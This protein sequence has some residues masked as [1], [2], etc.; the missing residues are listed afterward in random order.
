MKDTTFGGTCQID[1]LIEER[2]GLNSVL[3]PSQ[4]ARVQRRRKVSFK[5]NKMQFAKG[6]GSMFYIIT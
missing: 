4:E 2:Y 3:T 6:Y 1:K 5:R